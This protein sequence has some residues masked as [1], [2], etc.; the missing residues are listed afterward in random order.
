MKDFFIW[1]S[2]AVNI[3]VKLP[4]TDNT[5]TI[6]VENHSTVA[7]LLKKLNL[8]PDTVI[9]MNN[10]SPIPIDDTLKNNQELTIIQVSSGG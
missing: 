2:I 5:K 3:K 9:V 1:V 7:D 10:N 6:T 8:K 4:R